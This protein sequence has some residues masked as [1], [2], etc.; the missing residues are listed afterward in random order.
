MDQQ[1]ETEFVTDRQWDG[2]AKRLQNRNLK[3]HGK[4]L[5]ATSISNAA[6]KYII[7]IQSDRSGMVVKVGW[8]DAM[9]QAASR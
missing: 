8:R 2:L 7:E 5:S 1:T 9:R 4:S 3:A 6:N